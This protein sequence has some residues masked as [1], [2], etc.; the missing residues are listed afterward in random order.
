MADS[1]D[2]SR[3]RFLKGGAAAVAAIPLA[4]LVHQKQAF[5]KAKAEEGH[6][7]DYVH[8]AEEAVDHEAYQEGA[9]CDNCAFWAGEDDEHEGWGGCFHPDFSDVLVKAGGW[10]DVWAG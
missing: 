5:A 3:R 9:R 1:T 4:A 6:A 10:C 8:D 7:R 2:N